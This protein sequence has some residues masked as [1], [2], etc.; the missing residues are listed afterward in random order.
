MLSQVVSAVIS[1]AV[2]I[3]AIRNLTPGSWGHYTTAFALV[4][5]FMILS[6]PGLAQLALREMAVGPG[7][8]ADVLGASFQALGWTFCFATIGLLGATFALGYPRQ[9]VLL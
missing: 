1:G 7:H 8:E 3:Y 2:S 9:V 6:G 4:A 5:I